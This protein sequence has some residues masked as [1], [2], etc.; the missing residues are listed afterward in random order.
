M[1]CLVMNEE[2]LML[3][4]VKLRIRPSFTKRSLIV[5]ICVYDFVTFFW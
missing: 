5:Y 1:C 3:S 2:P 4:D